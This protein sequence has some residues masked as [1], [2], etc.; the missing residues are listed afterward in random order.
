MALF[1]VMAS[2]LRLDIA[3]L[4]D[5]GKAWGLAELSV[6]KAAA[7]DK[8]APA[9]VGVPLI[10]LALLLVQASLTALVAAFGLALAPLVGTVG[11]LALGAIVA[12]LGAVGLAVVAV[13]MF[14]GMIA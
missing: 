10:V 1:G 5:D 13:R 9:K 2:H 3:S 8:V 4:I 14:K 11:G 7:A 12:L 6:V